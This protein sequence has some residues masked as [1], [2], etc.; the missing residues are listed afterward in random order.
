M[1]LMVNFEDSAT[2]LMADG[3]KED[4]GAETKKV[5]YSILCLVFIQYLL[6][7]ILAF[8]FFSKGD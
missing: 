2:L 5:S 8:F 1:S 6:L 4:K 7:L 3:I